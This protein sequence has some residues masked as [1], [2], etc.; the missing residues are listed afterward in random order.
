MEARSNQWKLIV[1]KEMEARSN[2]WKLTAH[3]DPP[4]PSLAYFRRGAP[5]RA[6]LILVAVAQI[7]FELAAPA[8]E[9]NQHACDCELRGLH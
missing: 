1:V 2:Q 5:L 3:L 8:H 6:Q 7:Q 4:R 9:P